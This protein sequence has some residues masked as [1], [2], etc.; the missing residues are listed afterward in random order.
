MSRAT[1]HNSEGLESTAVN[2]FAIASLV[3]GI[4]WL[5]GVGSILAL[6]FG[7]VATGQI[8]RSGDRQ[9]GRGLALAG[10]V[11]GWVGV[12][13]LGLMLLWWWTGWMGWTP[14]PMD[15]MDGM[16]GMMGEGGHSH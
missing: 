3:M 15:M 14:A 9:S 5:M 12:G 16:G 11:L 7:H 13:F 8:E 6:V 1:S 2:G 4:V 10:I